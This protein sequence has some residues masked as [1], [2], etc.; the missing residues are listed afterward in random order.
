MNFNSIVKNKISLGF[1]HLLF[2][3]VLSGFVNSASFITC[4]KFVT[5]MTGTTTLIG[6]FVSSQNW[7][8]LLEICL[9]IFSFFSGAML[10]CLLI[11]DPNDQESQK[12]YDRTLRIV[13]STLALVA[14]S[15]HFGFFKLLN[16]HLHSYGDYLCISLLSMMSGM[17]NGA[18]TLASHGSV[19]TTHLT[20]LITDL[21]ISTMHLHILNRNQR[22][23]AHDRR[24]LHQRLGYLGGFVIGSISGAL[25]TMKLSFIAFLIPSILAVCLTFHLKKK[26]TKEHLKLIAS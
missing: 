1:V 20:G 25:F 15:G 12:Y 19:R 8:S 21:G 7:V 11:G 16:V 10:V 17:Q 6:I 5:H 3:F 22:E 4:A 18:I 14:I 26:E 2:L 13:A 23:L 9:I 24:I